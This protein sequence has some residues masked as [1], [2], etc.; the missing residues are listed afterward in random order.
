MSD[1]RPYTSIGL[2]R[3][4]PFIESEPCKISLDP[5]MIR[6]AHEPQDPPQTPVPGVGYNI[7]RKVKTRLDSGAKVIAAVRR[8]LEHTGHVIDDE[9]LATTI[10]TIID[11]DVL[12]FRRSLAYFSAQRAFFLC[13]NSERHAIVIHLLCRYD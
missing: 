12:A 4:E 2:P 9:T 13:S 8:A 10:S 6:A 1:Q 3:G 11:E 7:V 5:H